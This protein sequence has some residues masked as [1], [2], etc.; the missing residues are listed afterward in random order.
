[1]LFCIPCCNVCCNVWLFPLL[2]P[3]INNTFNTFSHR[4]AAD[5][6]FFYFSH[7]SLQTLENVVCENPRR[8]PS[9]EILKSSCLA[10]I[11]IPWLN[12]L[13]SH[14]FPILAFSMKNSWICWPCLHVLMLLWFGIL[15]FVFVYVFVHLFRFIISIIQSCILS[16]SCTRVPSSHLCVSV[17]T[18]LEHFPSLRLHYSVISG[19]LVSS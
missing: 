2:L 5:W 4:T 19:I 11:I 13:R 14:F 8:L 3:L 9:L 6:M 18:E 17:W 16:Y 10:S 15:C 1:M 12:S 7:H